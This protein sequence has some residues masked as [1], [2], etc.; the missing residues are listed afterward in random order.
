MINDPYTALNYILQNNSNITSLLSTYQ[1]TSI[2][3]IAGGVLAEV[4]TGLPAIVFNV[5]NHGEKFNQKQSI[6]TVNCYASIERDSFLLAKTVI[7]EL[8]GLQTTA[9]GY[10]VTLQADILATVPDP[11]AKEV[12]TAVEV[13][14]FNIGGAL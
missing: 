6:F 7:K 11:T 8:K 4:E 5:D 9:N 13:R 3:L 12:N 1:G 2:P 14:L 10:P